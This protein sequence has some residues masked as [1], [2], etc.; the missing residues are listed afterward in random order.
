[1][2]I[3]DMKLIKDPIQ[4]QL[5]IGFLQNN[6]FKIFINFPEKHQWRG[7]NKFI[8]SINNEIAC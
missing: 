4:K 2:L 6:Y 3:N 1:M 8:F 5:L 7:F